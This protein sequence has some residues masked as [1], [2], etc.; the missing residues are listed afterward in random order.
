[1]LRSMHPTIASRGVSLSCFV[2]LS[3]EHAG[4]QRSVNLLEVEQPTGNGAILKRSRS[5]QRRMR[6]AEGNAERARRGMVNAVQQQAASAAVSD[7]KLKSLIMHRGERFFSPALLRA[8]TRNRF[9]RRPIADY[10]RS[11]LRTEPFCSER[12]ARRFLVPTLFPTPNAS[13]REKGLHLLSPF[14]LVFVLPETLPFVSLSQDRRGQLSAPF[15][16][17]LRLST[18]RQ[19]MRRE[20]KKKIPKQRRQHNG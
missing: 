7:M 13:S 18:R 17:R 2:S 15:T 10:T 20:E 8:L 19:M 11:A 3:R 4:V 9:S 6:E 12:D 16:V 1:M 14:L 5:Q